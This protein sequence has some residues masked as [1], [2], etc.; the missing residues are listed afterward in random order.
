MSLYDEMFNQIPQR[1]ISMYKSKLLIE[2][3]KA[4]C[5]SKVGSIEREYLDGIIIEYDVISNNLFASLQ[6]NINPPK[7]EIYAR[8][9]GM[10]QNPRK[11][12]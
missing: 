12:E 7:L 8:K 9:S 2:A 11:L 5:R 1:E 3:V 4:Y 6:T 10:V